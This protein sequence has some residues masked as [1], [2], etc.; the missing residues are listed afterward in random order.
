MAAPGTTWRGMAQICLISPVSPDEYA[1]WMHGHF[2]ELGSRK[3]FGLV[4]TEQ[5]SPDPCDCRFKADDPPRYYKLRL[6]DFKTNKTVFEEVVEKTGGDYVNLYSENASF[7]TETLK[8]E[9][10]AKA[11]ITKFFNKI[12]HIADDAIVCIGKMA[13]S[14]P[15]ETKPEGEEPLQ[16]PVGTI[17]RPHRQHWCPH[18]HPH[19]KDDG[20][21]ISARHKASQGKAPSITLDTADQKST[22]QL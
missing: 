12:S 1:S 16:P 18:D 7:E 22:L 6:L 20:E 5:A 8:A 15:P 21:W 17:H 11:H 14:V 9:A 4:A 3:C 10:Q 13:I 19:Q 2:I